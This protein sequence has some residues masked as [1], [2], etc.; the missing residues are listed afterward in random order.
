MQ[1]LC[2]LKINNV[3]INSILFTSTYFTNIQ[4]ILE[5]CTEKHSLAHDLLYWNMADKRNNRLRRYI[6]LRFT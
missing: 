2:T 3:L 4:R 5:R 1:K 6:I